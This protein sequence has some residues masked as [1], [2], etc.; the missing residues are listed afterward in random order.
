MDWE[1]TKS[2]LILAFLSLN[3][4]FAS[5]L[6][7]APAFLDSKLI[8]STEQVETKKAELRHNNIEVTAEIPRRIQPQRIL[9]LRNSGLNWGMVA[10]S[11]LGV[12]MVTDHY[13]SNPHLVA[14]RYRSSK[15]EVVVDKDKILHYNSGL[16][17]G[18]GTLTAEEAMAKAE[19]FLQVT[20]GK[21][22]DA[23]IG[24]ALEGEGG[25]WLVEY[26]Q[27][28]RRR[29]VETSWIWIHVDAQ[30]ILDMEY[31]WVDVVGFSGEKIATIPATGALTIIAENLQPGTTI[32]KLY[33]S[34]YS[35]PVSTQQ[36]H[37]Y[38][39][40]VVETDNGSKYYINAFT[41]DIEGS[42]DFRQ[43]NP[44]KS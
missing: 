9:T 7:L 40:W 3:I 19:A 21:P 43:E 36:W 35:Q 29:D 13:P 4:F 10:R 16:D 8:I 33:N 42:R 37:S 14:Y 24:R 31:Y 39:V 17:A 23:V 30:G 41:G 11:I 22:E 12:G 28:W 34:W 6:W 26:C 20:V 2:V 15:G 44:K 27:R 32:I 5:Q 18:N 25:T 38:P 1:R